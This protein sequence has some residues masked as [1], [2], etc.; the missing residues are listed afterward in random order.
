M[1]CPRNESSPGDS[2]F[3]GG[4]IGYTI[5]DISFKL[6]VEYGAGTSYNYDDSYYKTSDSGAG[7]WIVPSVSVAW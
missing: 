6:G 7:L 4:D 5:S 1:K 2:W 3:V